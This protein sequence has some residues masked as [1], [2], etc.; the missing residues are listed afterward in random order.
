MTDKEFEKTKQE[1]WEKF[2]KGAYPYT[3]HE[4]INFVLD[5]IRQQKQ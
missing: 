3:P 1:C 4:A 5:F 2:K